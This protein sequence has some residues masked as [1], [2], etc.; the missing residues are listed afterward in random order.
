MRCLYKTKHLIWSD[1]PLKRNILLGYLFKPY[2]ISFT[3]FPKFKYIEIQLFNYFRWSQGQKQPPELF[4]IKKLFFKNV[5]YSQ[6]KTCV[7]VSF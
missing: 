1:E 2:N 4:F 3:F 6:E 5:Q 7:G